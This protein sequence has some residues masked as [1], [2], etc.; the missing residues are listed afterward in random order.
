MAK[1]Y[2]GTLKL[3]GDPVAFLENCVWKTMKATRIHLSSL[4]MK[5]CPSVTGVN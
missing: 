4:S 2:Y 1:F 3:D 5:M